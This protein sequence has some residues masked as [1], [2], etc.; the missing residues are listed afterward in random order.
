TGRVLLAVDDAH[1]L[2]DASAAFVH[3]VVVHG[4]A[5]VVAT[6]RGAERTPDAIHALWKDGLAVRVDVPRLPDDAIDRLI[7]LALDGQV[8]GPARTK[9][10]S[11][12]AG[13]PLYLRE[14]VLAATESGALR[15]HDGVWV[16][17]GW[18]AG[19]GRLA[20]LVQARLRAADPAVRAVAE[21]V[22][23]GEPGP[24]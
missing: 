16:W 20:D 1:L 9:L 11:S 14:L 22:A 17:H 13:N 18:P 2:D 19:P 12:A 4:H 7:D 10:R 6:V 24:L 8:S 3:H 5:L 21:L 15:H 23:C